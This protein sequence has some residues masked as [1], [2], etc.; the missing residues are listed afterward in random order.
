[1]T[2]TTHNA[3]AY[4]LAGGNADPIANTPATMETTT[5]IM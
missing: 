4:S 2:K 1:M 5:V 3:T